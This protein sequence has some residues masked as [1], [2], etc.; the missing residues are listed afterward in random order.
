MA[1]YCR[2]Y[3]IKRVSSSRQQQAAL[4]CT[5]SD[6]QPWCRDMQYWLVSIHKAV[7]DIVMCTATSLTPKCGLASNAY[8]VCL[9]SM[10]AHMCPAC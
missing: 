10:H 5:T 3:A 8:H 6:P 7:I 9:V 1:Y 2:L 4:A